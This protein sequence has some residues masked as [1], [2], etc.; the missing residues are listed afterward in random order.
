[1]RHLL[2]IAASISLAVLAACGDGEEDRVSPTSTPAPTQTVPSA[3]A[4]PSETP[5]AERAPTPGPGR[6]PGWLVYRDRE[7]GFEIE[8]PALAHLN[9]GPGIPYE[10]IERAPA[11][12]IDLPVPSHALVDLYVLISV[13]DTSPATC[14]PDEVTEEMEVAPRL[15]PTPE[16]VRYGDV[17]FKKHTTPAAMAMHG[18]LFSTYW[19]LKGTTCVVIDTVVAS[20]NPSA[21]AVTPVPFDQEGAEVTL[22]SI[23]SS[24]RWLP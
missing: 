21:L 23:V 22:L 5:N 16:V 24:F 2:L 3:E 1:M 8:Y 15:A 12:R 6:T 11:A 17:E 13:A 19:T 20:Y 4:S 9:E 18:W 14:E 10:I 7:F